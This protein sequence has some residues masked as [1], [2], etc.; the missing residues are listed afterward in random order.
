MRIGQIK[1][2][3]LRR[4]LARGG[5]HS[6][7]LSAGGPFPSSPPTR[8]HRSSRPPHEGAAVRMRLP[9]RY[10]TAGGT[11]AA[12]ASAYLGP[13]ILFSTANVTNAKTIA[14]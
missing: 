11:V 14:L 9:N 6:P 3:T 13:T 7:Q 5:E 10:A 12:G 1:A 2:E 8:Q 4:R